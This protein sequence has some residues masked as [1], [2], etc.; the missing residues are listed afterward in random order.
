[1]PLTTWRRP[2]LAP[3]YALVTAFLVVTG[4]SLA[5]AS[6][7]APGTV[8]IGAGGDVRQL[9]E[10]ASFSLGD[11]QQ[12]KPYKVELNRKIALTD[13]ITRVCLKV[14]EPW[15]VVE[16]LLTDDCVDRVAG[17]SLTITVARSARVHVVSEGQ[18]LPQDVTVTLED[19]QDNTR[20]ETGPL[21]PDGYYRPRS[22]LSG[23]RIC[24]SAFGWTTAD[25]QKCQ[26]PVQDTANDVE[27][28]LVRK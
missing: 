11:R 13:D 4:V 6:Q 16:P 14:P 8:T 19:E 9:T 5:T 18:P 12:T 15:R 25:G 28:K 1:M 7:N 27:I 22:S 23:E 17:S 20:S 10:N 3:V 21:G 2:I 26:K 24:V